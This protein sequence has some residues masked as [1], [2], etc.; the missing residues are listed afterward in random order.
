MEVCDPNLDIEFEISISFSTGATYELHLPKSNFMK[1]VLRRMPHLSIRNG[2]VEE[3]PVGIV[4][5]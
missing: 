3:A 5:S 4:Q 2:D 1:M